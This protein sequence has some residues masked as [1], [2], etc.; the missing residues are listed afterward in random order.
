MNPK[1]KLPEDSQVLVEIGR[2]IL[3]QQS[4][5]KA[6]YYLIYEF[7]ES[8]D[9]R[10]YWPRGAGDSDLEAAKTEMMRITGK[11]IS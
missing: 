1:K 9:G 11:K 5:N 4:L 6:P 2:Y 8:D 10:R 3:V 7:Y